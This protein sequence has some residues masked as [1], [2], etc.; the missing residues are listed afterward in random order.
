MTHTPTN[1]IVGEHAHVA[2]SPEIPLGW[3]LPE[4]RAHVWLSTSGNYVVDGVNFTVLNGQPDR[5]SEYAGPVQGIAGVEVP[6]GPPASI[7]GGPP[8]GIPGR[9]GA[10]VPEPGFTALL[11]MLLLVAGVSG[12]WRKRL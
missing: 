6:G 11:G 12:W 10:E 7:P 2:V 1:I 8:R 4:T 3:R 5:P 9:P